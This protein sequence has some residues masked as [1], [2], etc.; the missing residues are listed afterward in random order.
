MAGLLL[1]PLVGCASDAVTPT[2]VWR[3]ATPAPE[4]RSGYAAGV[5]GGRLILI[6]GSYWEGK[7]DQWE[8]KRFC[9]TVDAF[10][11][12]TGR[13]EKLPDAPKSFCYAAYT[14]VGEEIYVL[15]GLQ[16][17]VASREIWALGPTQDG[18]RWRQCGE[19]PGTRLFASAM[20]V[21]SKIY[22]FGGVERFE[23]LD[24]T[25]SCCTTSS[26]TNALALWDTAKPDAGWTNLP[27]LPGHARW[28]QQAVIDGSALY[29]F[30]GIFQARVSDPST[31]FNQVWRYDLDAREWQLLADLPEDLQGAAVLVAARRILLIGA[32]KHAASFE[33]RQRTFTPLAP[34]PE[35]AT[36]DRFVWLAPFL[37]GA[38]GENELQ[39]PRRRSEWTFVGRFE[40]DP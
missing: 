39:G 34:L 12:R 22:L 10:D 27:P 20:A 25:G 14:Q 30:G 17:G 13:W 36:V 33:P 9:A 38:S 8:R 16:D 26:A 15:G 18:L 28:L 5:I 32:T 23:P 3:H 31:S 7:K 37:V 24:D 1:L 2:L 29:V 4:P 6:G 21:G 19:L 35:S 40:P 11:P